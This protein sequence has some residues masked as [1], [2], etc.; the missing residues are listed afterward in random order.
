MTFQ[1]PGMHTTETVVR[2]TIQKRRRGESAILLVV[3]MMPKK[4]KGESAKGI[5]WKPQNS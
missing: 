2:G 3:P 5:K 1:T 4:G